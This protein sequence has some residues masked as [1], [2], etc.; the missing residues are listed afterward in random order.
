MLLMVEE[1]DLREKHCTTL[2]VAMSVRDVF[3]E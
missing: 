3:I 1:F 2:L